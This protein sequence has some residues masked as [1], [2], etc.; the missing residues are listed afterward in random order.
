[1]VSIFNVA[2]VLFCALGA[3]MC[4][5]VRF[6]SGLIAIGVGAVFLVGAAVVDELRKR[7]ALIA[8]PDYMLGPGDRKK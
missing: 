3:V 5:L 4:L 6:D 2:G 7:L 1:M 8:R